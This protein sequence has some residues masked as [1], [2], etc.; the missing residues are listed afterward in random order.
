M[1]STGEDPYL[2]G[3]MAA[4]MVKGY[5]GTD[6]KE[7]GRLASCVKHFAGYGAPMGGKEYNQVELS[8][9]TLKQDYLPACQLPT[10]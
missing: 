6:L 9:R 2:N 10:T 4:E 1:E 3:V 5:Q 7:E 8:E